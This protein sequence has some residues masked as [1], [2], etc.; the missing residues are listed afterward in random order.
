MLIFL[1]DGNIVAYINLPR[2]IVDFR[3]TVSSDR[4]LERENTTFVALRAESFWQGWHSTQ[5]A[6]WDVGNYLPLR[7]GH[8]AE[9]VNEVRSNDSEY[10]VIV[11]PTTDPDAI[12]RHELSM[13]TE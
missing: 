1:N 6:H 3:G 4:I 9:F 10:Y 13:N 11:E 2:G 7:N 8:W 12:A 5:L